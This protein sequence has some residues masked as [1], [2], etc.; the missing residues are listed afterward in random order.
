LL[1]RCVFQGGGGSH[2]RLAYAVESNAIVHLH[3]QSLLFF[4]HSN[5]TQ[6]T[7]PI[8]A[9]MNNGDLNG[10][11]S[12][13]TGG[14][15]V[16]IATTMAEKLS[17]QDVLL[18]LYWYLKHKRSGRIK[19]KSDDHNYGDQSSSSSSS[20]PPP[21]TSQSS[22]GAAAA[23]AAATAMMTLDDVIYCLQLE[24]ILFWRDPRFLQS[25]NVALSWI[26]NA[27]ETDELPQ[28]QQQQ[29]KA[30]RIQI[31]FPLFAQL[32]TPCARLFLNAFNEQFVIPDWSSFASDLRYFYETAGSS[33]K[34]T[35][36]VL[37]K[38]LTLR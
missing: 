33:G 23:A 15:D 3:R 30:G 29:Q 26:K 1:L 36:S 11:S 9:T 17:C 34:S 13:R 22:S 27:E 18:E 32:V 20:E 38:K 35:L 37:S 12:S 25:Q 28:Q 24:G 19:R 4:D 6:P 21:A 7:T 14:I 2:T 16:S 5:L 8:P 10:G 31:S